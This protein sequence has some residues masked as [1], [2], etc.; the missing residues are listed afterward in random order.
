MARF[1]IVGCGC[2][3]QAL[4]RELIA[5]GHVVRGTTRDPA[6]LEAIEAAGAEGVIADPYRL[7]TVMPLLDGASA[8]CWL[9]GTASGDAAEVAALHGGRL[10]ALLDKLVDTHVR[11]A[12]YEAAGSVDAATLSAG[13]AL[14]RERRERY[15]MPIE[16]VDADPSDHPRWLEATAA[17]VERVLAA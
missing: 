15:R 7:A 2:R 3:G 16:I 9:M 12:V 6:K 1:L 11:G 14:A 8:V 5:A 4:A 17:A 10:E 13:A